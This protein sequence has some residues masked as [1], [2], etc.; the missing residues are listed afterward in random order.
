M[1][2]DI[3]A[4]A[5]R[6]LRSRYIFPDKA[7]EAARLV[8]T[9]RAAEAYDG[10][11]EA[12]LGE[13]ITA[14]LFT[15][16]ADKHLRVRQ[17]DPA[18]GTTLTPEELE[19]AWYERE[20]LEGYRIVKVER[21]P[22]N[23]GLIELSGIADAANGGRAIAAAME[24]VAQTHAL[25]FDL[26]SNRGGSP[27][28]VTFWC[29]FLF[30]DSMTHLNSIYDG[31]SGR[32]KQFWSLPWLPGPRYL[33]RPVYVLCGGDTFSAGEEFCYNLK[34]LGR[35]ALIGEVT[36]GGAHPTDFLP[37]SETMEITIPIARSV[38]PLTETNWEG[39]GVE[40]DVVVPVAEA[41]AVA[42]RAALRHVVDSSASGGIRDQAREAL[43][44]LPEGLPDVP[45]P[46]PT[47]RPESEEPQHMPG[48]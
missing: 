42:Y 31:E 14:D 48:E 44:G 47:A 6:L 24:L 46:K 8:E 27:D 25:I 7:E 29:S 2:D 30:K 3:I 19:A 41:Y 9:H 13:R 12:A 10:L 1:P 33:D 40:P 45:A 43:G 15:V 32:T 4:E 23:V 5:L 17:R 16:C 37:L 18:L 11:D 39:V 21:L 34:H 36:R 22:G 28:G 38:H 35:A 26:R 20:R